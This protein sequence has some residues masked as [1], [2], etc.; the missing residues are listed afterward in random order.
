MEK[1]ENKSLMWRPSLNFPY[2][3][4]LESDFW[5]SDL[6]HRSGVSLSE[7]DKNIYVEADLPGLQTDDIELSF[8][9]G[10]LMIRGS[11]TEEEKGKK[12]KYYR[13]ASSSF[14]YR[15]NLPDQINEGKEPDA[16]YKNGVLTVTFAK[17][18]G[19]AP[20]KI[21]VKKAA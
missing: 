18:A 8:E 14:F 11:R 7:D 4:E 5:K 13:K 9:R 21:P 16:S 6:A 2:L 19:T 20:K 17:A 12:K 15:V 1:E 3:E 10:V